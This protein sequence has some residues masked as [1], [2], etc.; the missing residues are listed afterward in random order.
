MRI[1]RVGDRI[2][3]I[4]SGMQIVTPRGGAGLVVA[5]VTEIAGLDLGN[6]TTPASS[7]LVL[8][9]S[10]T[11][12][13]FWTRYSSV[14]RISLSGSAFTTAT[15]YMYCYQ[16]SAPIDVSLFRIAGGNDWILGEV[17]FNYRKGTTEW[18][19]GNTACRTT[20]TDYI[21]GAVDTQA[22]VDVGWYAF[23]ITSAVKAWLA[24]PASNQGLV[25]LSGTETINKF[26]FFRG[27]LDAGLEPYVTIT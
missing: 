4:G 20:G 9:Y 14:M 5:T 8:V 7:S 19:G 13:T 10:H 2:L 25:V 11:I 27:L 22:I 26:A 3:S 12:N 24:D 15:L 1:Q 18:L 16:R 17:C 21:D 6:P 23:D